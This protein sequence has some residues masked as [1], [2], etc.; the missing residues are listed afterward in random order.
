MIDVPEEAADV[1]GAAATDY[2]AQ[3][4]QQ[5]LKQL[6]KR[7]PVKIDKKVLKSVRESQLKK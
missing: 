1:R 3:L 6:R 4:E 5:W 2:Q 7:Y